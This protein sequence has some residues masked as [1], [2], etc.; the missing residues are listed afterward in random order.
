MLAAI[1]FHLLY[2]FYSGL[3]FIAGLACYLWKSAFHPR[4]VSP[5]VNGR[6]V[7]RLP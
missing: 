4:P 2:H 6:A 3:S 1:P 7:N 5:A